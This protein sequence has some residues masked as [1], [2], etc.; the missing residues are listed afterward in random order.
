MRNTNHE[1]SYY[2]AFSILLLFCLV[3][4]TSLGNELA[5][6]SRHVCSRREQLDAFRCDTPEERRNTLSPV[7]LP[8]DEIHRLQDKLLHHSRAEEVALKRVRDLEMQL[9]RV[10]KNEEVTH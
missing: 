8:L 6:C 7:C 4:S 9:K 10:K 2:A 5:V 3:I 1:P